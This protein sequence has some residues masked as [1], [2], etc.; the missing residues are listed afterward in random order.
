LLLAVPFMAGEA[1]SLGDLGMTS[2]RV[3]GVLGVAVALSRWIIPFWMD[4]VI[5]SRNRE[6]FLI[7]LIVVCLGTA[8]TTLVAG[9]SV[10]LG[11]F[12]AGMAIAESGYGHHTLSEVSPF[13]DLLIS[14]FFISIGMLLDVGVLAS[15]AWLAVLILLAVLAIKFVSGFAPVLAWGFP[16]SVATTVGVAIA[17]IGEFSFVL[18]HAGYQA[19]LIDDDVYSMFLVVAV[20]SMIVS[21]FIVSGA[22]RLAARLARV[23]GL[24]RFHARAAMGAEQDQPLENH[25]II[26][27]FGLNGRNVA[28]ALQSLEI[29]FVV[30][31]MNPDAVQAGRREGKPIFFGDCSRAEA[32]QKLRIN[33]ARGLVL[34]VSDSQAV[35]QAVQIARHENPRLHIIVRTK[36]MNEIDALRALGAD[37]I[38]AEEFETSLEVLSLTLRMFDTPGPAIERV[39]AHFRSNAYQA[40]RSEE[41]STMQQQLRQSLLSE[42]D[43]ESHRLAEEE[44]AIG[45]SLRELDLRARTGATL[46]AVRRNSELTAV[47]AADFQ[48]Q[49]G[50]LLILAGNGRQIADAVQVVS[51]QVP[52]RRDS[53]GS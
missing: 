31:E 53:P 22:S 34:A 7:F 1:V 14:V 28:A 47:P 33:A 32:L 4:H 42:F 52:G 45:Q 12:L 3:C 16:L 23:P 46:L 38:V 10:G 15:G 13:R 26:A 49:A 2:L 24:R 5:R 9:L 40:L 35:R 27:G 6:L 48:L 36:Y 18:A 41:S 37:E 17:Q 11:A 20:A 30:L 39:V 29:P 43:F 19:E 44:P 21:P 25:V 51:G 8:W 50:D